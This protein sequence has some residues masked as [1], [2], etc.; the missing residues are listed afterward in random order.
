VTV[1]RAAGA[2]TVNWDG[3]DRAQLVVRDT[4]KPTSAAAIREL[5]QLVSRLCS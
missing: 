5:K 4:I 3:V 1:G 2:I